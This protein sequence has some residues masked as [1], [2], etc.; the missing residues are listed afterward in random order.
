MGE[1]NLGRSQGRNSCELFQTLWNAGNCRCNHRNPFADLD[2]NEAQLEDL[3]EQ[4]HPDDCMT[5]EGDRL[6]QVPLY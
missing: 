1:A 6:I 5:S 2:E 4:L 3:V